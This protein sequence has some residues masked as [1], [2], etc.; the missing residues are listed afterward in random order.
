MSEEKSVGA[1]FVEGIFGLLKQW[2]VWLILIVGGGLLWGR[3]DP[4]MLSSFA[5]KAVQIIK[6]L[7]GG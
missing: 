5:D 4:N 7:K 3:L 1:A 2:W 6:A